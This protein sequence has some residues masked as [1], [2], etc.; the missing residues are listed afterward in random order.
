MQLTVPMGRSAVELFSVV[1]GVRPTT[2]L[3]VLTLLRPQLR[4]SMLWRG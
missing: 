4:D 2:V 1:L 3:D